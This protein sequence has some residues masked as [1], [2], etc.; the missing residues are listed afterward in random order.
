LIG[1]TGLSAYDIVITFESE[2]L[3]ARGS[4]LELGFLL[5]AVI[6]FAVGLMLSSSV[7]ARFSRGALA[8]GIGLLLLGIGVLALRISGKAG[9]LGLLGAILP[10]LALSLSALI[11]PFGA[12]ASWRRPP[13]K[14]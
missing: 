10:V 5:I 3:S 8:L 13:E 2:S 4:Y 7:T 12:A 6:S 14:R 9:D 11:L 1:E